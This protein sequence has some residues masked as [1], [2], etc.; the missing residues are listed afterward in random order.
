M[1]DTAKC[2]H[3]ACTC[4][5]AKGGAWGKYCSEQCKEKGEQTELRCGCH[6][7]GCS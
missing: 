2:A 4:T 7:P 1:A 3:P 5:V 6:H